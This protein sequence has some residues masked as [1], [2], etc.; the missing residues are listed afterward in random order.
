MPAVAR[1]VAVSARARRCV[2]AATGQGRGRGGGG[3]RRRAGGV[4]RDPYD[5][6]GVATD[7]SQAE[8]KLAFRKL[9]RTYHPDVNPDENAAARFRRINAAYEIV[10]DVER[11]RR[12]DLGQDWEVRPRSLRPAGKKN[13]SR[14]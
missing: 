3:Y 2:R 12:F 11:R 5:T 8:V 4:L 1:W 9:V 13:N 10:G 7:A 14:S 6:L